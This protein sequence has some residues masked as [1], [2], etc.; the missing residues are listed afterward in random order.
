MINSFDFVLKA[1]KRPDGNID[2]VR[3]DL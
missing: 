2:L 1:I 3:I